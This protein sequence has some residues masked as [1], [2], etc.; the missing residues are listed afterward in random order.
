MQT[1]QRR[2][3]PDYRQCGGVQRSTLTMLLVWLAIA[4]VLWAGF[5]WWQER[6][7]AALVP[8]TQAGG[9]LVIPRSPD[10]HFYVDGAVNHVPVHFLIDT[11]SSAVAITD[12]V[13]RAAQLPRG[14]AIV[15]STAAGPREARR[16]HN[17]PVQAGPLA[18]NDITVVTGLQMPAADALLGQSFLQHFDVQIDGARMR[19]R[20]R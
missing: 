13:A 3:S 12:A 2:C 10:G 17:V 8:Y 11:G 6:Q 4:F 18:R 14:S 1:P 15:V 7:R 16:I 9:E 20:A 19:L 5:H